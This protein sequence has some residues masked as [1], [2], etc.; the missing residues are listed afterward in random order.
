MYQK[1]QHAVKN[2]RSMGTPQ[3]DLF[4]IMVSEKADIY[5]RGNSS[6][7]SSNE[8]PNDYWIYFSG[9]VFSNFFLS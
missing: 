4:S 1:F 7:S 2:Q 8:L 5:I 3:Q 9:F 6:T